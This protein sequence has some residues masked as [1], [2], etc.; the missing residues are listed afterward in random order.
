MEMELL[1][2]MGRAKELVNSLVE[3][4]KNLIKYQ[5]TP[6][7]RY[8]IFIVTFIVRNNKT[9]ADTTLTVT[10]EDFVSMST[11]S[12]DPQKAFF[13]GKLKVKGNIMLTQKLGAILKPENI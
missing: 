13:N 10:D 5:K 8:G 12:L 1:L 9:T 3:T 6:F 2:K 11:G 7:I 4:L